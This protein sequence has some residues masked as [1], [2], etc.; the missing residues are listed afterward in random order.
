[1]DFPSRPCY[2]TIMAVTKAGA[3][4]IAAKKRGLSVQEY[5]EKARAQKWCGGCKNWHPKIEFGKDATRGDGLSANCFN[6]RRR[7]GRNK[8]KKKPMPPI[9]RSFVP[10]R[11]GDKKQARRRINYFV[12]MGLLPHPN[13]VPCFDCGDRWFP[14]GARHEY[15]HHLGYAKENHENVQA[16]CSTCHHKRPSK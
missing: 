9:G 10:A 3:L 12:E 1:M 11:E 8:Y 4:K 16:V 2:Y 13:D 5:L 6:H 15:D 14:G 7:S